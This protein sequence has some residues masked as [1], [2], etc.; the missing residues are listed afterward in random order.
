MYRPIAIRFSYH[1]TYLI[2][3]LMTRH[4]TLS[5]CIMGTLR[6]LLVQV[7]YITRAR[8]TDRGY[9]VQW[10]CCAKFFVSVSRWLLDSVPSSSAAPRRAYKLTIFNDQSIGNFHHD[11]DD[12]YL[13]SL[14][15]PVADRVKAAGDTAQ[16]TLELDVSDNR[17][18]LG[19]SRRGLSRDKVTC[20]VIDF[21]FSL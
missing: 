2:S 15:S 10:N 13:L 12:T 9:C 20:T 7:P 11:M 18:T 21:V 8:E 17:G 16:V 3:P 6:T 5:T 19:N 4:D 14:S 1:F